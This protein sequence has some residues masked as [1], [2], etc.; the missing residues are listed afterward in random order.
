MKK[1]YIF[2]DLP[3]K[4]HL[5][6]SLAVAVFYFSQG[7]Y[8]NNMPVQPLCSQHAYKSGSTCGTK[9]LIKDLTTD[10]QFSKEYYDTKS[11]T[12]TREEALALLKKDLDIASN[13][14]L[15]KML[16]MLS[17]L[18]KYNVTVVGETNE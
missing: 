11:L 13:R 5:C 3:T 6:D 8:C 7:C 4:C 14:T 18:F 16:S 2:N 10:N 9:E 17:I 12:V 15:G 1:D